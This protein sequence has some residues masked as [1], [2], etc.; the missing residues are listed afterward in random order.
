MIFPTLLFYIITDHNLFLYKAGYLGLRHLQ[1]VI[2]TPIFLGLP[3]L[4]YKH[5]HINE[6]FKEKSFATVVLLLIFIASL[7][8]PSL[9]LSSFT[10]FYPDYVACFDSYAQKLK[11]HNG[12]SSYWVSR[13]MTMYNQSGVHLA[14]IHNNFTP[15]VAMVSLADYQRKQYDFLVSTPGIYAFLKQ[16]VIAKFG[17]PY[18]TFN[19]PENYTFYVYKNHEMDKIFAKLD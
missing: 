19:C 16:N 6:F 17:K 10:H 11:L 18:T 8:R 14:S 15:F 12:I 2:L 13:N 3:L 1:P 9:Q 4:I 5:T 7:N